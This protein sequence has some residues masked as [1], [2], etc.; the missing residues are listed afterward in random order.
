ML[1]SIYQPTSG[2]P[3]VTVLLLS[4]AFARAL[5]DSESTPPPPLQLRMVISLSPPLFDV[6]DERNFERCRVRNRTDILQPSLILSAT[7]PAI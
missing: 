6:F 5:T 3:T 2:L 4:G 1:L 7:L